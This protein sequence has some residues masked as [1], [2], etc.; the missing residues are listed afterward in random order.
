MTNTPRSTIVGINDDMT[1]LLI[2]GYQLDPKEH[3]LEDVCPAGHAVVQV[4]LEVFEK[5]LAKVKKMRMDS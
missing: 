2:V 4:S 5:A 1:V 3:D